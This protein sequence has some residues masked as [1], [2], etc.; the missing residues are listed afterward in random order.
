MRTTITLDDELLREAKRRATA[1]GGTLS[2]LVSDALRADLARIEHAAAE[3]Y[4]VTPFGEGGVRAS[5]DLSDGRALRDLLNEDEKGP[6]WT[7][8]M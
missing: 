1:R 5:V 7:S 2:E 8:G 4:R 3:P 6:P